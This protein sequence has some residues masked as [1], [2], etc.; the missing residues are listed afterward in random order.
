MAAT[1]DTPVHLPTVC[2][3]FTPAKADIVRQILERVGDKWSLLIISTLR[4]GPVRYSD[5]HRAI[6][7]I[8]YRM[9]TLTLTHLQRDGLVTRTSYPEIPPRVEYALTPM[10]TT[11]LDSALALVGWAVDHADA[12]V[13]HRAAFDTSA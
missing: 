10:G 12:V 13:E 5:L 11:L 7:V 3:T 4:E 9:L 8:S 1:H 6:P 2:E